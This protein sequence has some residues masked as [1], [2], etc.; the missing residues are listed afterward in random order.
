MSGILLGWMGM[1]TDKIITQY[2]MAVDPKGTDVKYY[3][4]VPFYNLLPG[5]DI[6]KMGSALD[7]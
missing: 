1:R 6:W 2:K 4:P 7:M 3:L 5:L